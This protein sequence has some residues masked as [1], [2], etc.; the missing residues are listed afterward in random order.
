MLSSLIDSMRASDSM[1]S[2]LGAKLLAAGL[3]G[4]FY[5]YRS[6]YDR[7]PCLLDYIAQSLERRAVCEEVIDYEHSVAGIEI[8]L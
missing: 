3:E 4:F 5:R 1:R 2:P 7:R 8:T 6:A